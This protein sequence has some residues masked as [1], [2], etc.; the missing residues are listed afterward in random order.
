[1]SL[2]HSRRFLVRVV[3]CALAAA[4]PSGCAL[5]DHF[6]YPTGKSDVLAYRAAMAET[7]VGMLRADFESLW[8]TDVEGHRVLAVTEELRDGRKIRR[9]YI[10]FTIEY[11]EASG[12]DVD[13]ERRDV[14]IPR[15][16][17][18]QDSVQL[19]APGPSADYWTRVRVTDVVT[20]VGDFVTGVDR[21]E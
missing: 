7:E 6:R 17:A 21:P 4:V 16:P 5:V 1:M 19:R 8:A 13:S 10:G 11:M 20:T 2:R 15:T 18:E 12:R 3:A 14:F 9:Y